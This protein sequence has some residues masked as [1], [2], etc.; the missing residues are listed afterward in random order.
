MDLL[1]TTD[2][3]ILVPTGDNKTFH[4]KLGIQRFMYTWYKTLTSFY[5]KKTQPLAPGKKPPFARNL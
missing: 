1:A 5:L 3:L 2:F 4:K